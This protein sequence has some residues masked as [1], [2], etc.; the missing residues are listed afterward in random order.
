MH[1]LL[2]ADILSGRFHPGERLKFTPLCQRYNASVG[3]IR[4]VLSR[5]TEQGL[6]RAQPQVG[7]EVT[8]ISVEDLVDLT[9]ARVDIEGLAL[10]RS[11]ERAKLPWK[12]QVIASHY[13]LEQTPRRDPEDPDR[14][15][16]AWEVAHAAFHDTLLAG[17]GSERLYAIARSLRD[18]AELYRRWS[19][20]L[21]EIE[22]ERDVAAEHRRILDLTVAGQADDAV[23]ALAEHI[24]CT[25]RL[26]LEAQGAGEAM[27]LEATGS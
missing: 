3:L 17:C 2:R 8:P 6:V 1:A 24:C 10:R 4:E 26:V 14:I 9:R 18:S 15:N 11:I 25:T 23:K 13:T 16:D 21:G 7:F 5:L 27:S 20:P 19:L 22:R 12:S